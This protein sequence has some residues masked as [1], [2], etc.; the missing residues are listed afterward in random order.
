MLCTEL[1][2]DIQNIFYT[3]CSPPCSAKRKAFDKDLPVKI[4]FLYPMKNP[5]ADMNNISYFV[6]LHSNYILENSYRGLQSWEKYDSGKPCK[7]H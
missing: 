3:K 6:F 7:P 2:S 1:V 5:F 4:G